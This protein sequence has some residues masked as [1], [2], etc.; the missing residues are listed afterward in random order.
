M[1]MVLE[2]DLFEEYIKF[3]NNLDFN[4]N[5][6]TRLLYFYKDGFLPTLEQ[7]KNAEKSIQG[8]DKSAFLLP[9]P[10]YNFDDC[11]ENLAKQT[12]LK[13]ILSN[14]KAEF[15]Y[16][17][18]NNDKLE[19]NLSATFKHNESRN[20][21]KEHIRALFENANNILI[22]DKYIQDNFDNFRNFIK[23]CLPDKQIN[24]FFTFRL[25]NARESEIKTIN[26]K[27]LIK[28]DRNNNYPVSSTHDRYILIDQKIEIILTSGID[29]LYDESKDF[30][31]IIRKK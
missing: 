4:H 25:D 1:Y 22:C 26:N 18:I 11:V 16:I 19:N 15:P 29:Y 13:I 12:K 17:N 2:D 14:K 5:I 8:F 10:S 21:A 30:T 20:K 27:Y 9:I 24:L 6:I 31:Y 3:K 7:L 23:E 28:N